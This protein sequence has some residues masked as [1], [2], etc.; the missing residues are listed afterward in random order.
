MN[1]EISVRNCGIREIFVALKS[2]GNIMSI[3]KRL[4]KHWG[5]EPKNKKSLLVKFSETGLTLRK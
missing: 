3:E 5:E 2:M 4:T 1:I